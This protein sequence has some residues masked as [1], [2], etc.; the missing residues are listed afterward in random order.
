M[1]AALRRPQKDVQNEERPFPFQLQPTFVAPRSTK[2]AIG[3]LP[4]QPP[5]AILDVDEALATRSIHERT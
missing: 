2:R 4:I 3:L 1:M 5:N